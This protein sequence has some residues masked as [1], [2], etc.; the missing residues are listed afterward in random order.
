MNPL[1]QTNNNKCNISSEWIYVSNS[2]IHNKGV[3]AFKDIPR[4]IEVIQYTGRKIRKKDAENLAERDKKTGTV[5][6]FEL[7]RHFYIDG[8]DNGSDATYVNHS[9]NPN[10]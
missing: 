6:L 5:Y 4:S 1:I 7:N 2:S 8:A 3:F 9:C 10:C